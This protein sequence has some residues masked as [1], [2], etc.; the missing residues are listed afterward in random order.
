MWQIMAMKQLWK[1]RNRLKNVIL[2]GQLKQMDVS[3]Q[4][5]G[6]DKGWYIAPIQSANDRN[7]VLNIKCKSISKVLS[8]NK[9]AKRGR[10]NVR[11][12]LV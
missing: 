6:Q 5:K 2:G 7:T 8:T 3:E 4:R 12:Q 11:R 10:H 9:S 1:S